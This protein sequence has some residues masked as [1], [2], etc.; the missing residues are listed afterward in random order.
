MNI[1][2]IG[3][4]GV[5]QCKG[6]DE[7]CMGAFEKAFIEGDGI[8][9]DAAV[10][11]DGTVYLVHDIA[12]I[13][14]PHIFHR[15]RYALRDHLD[16]PSRKKVGRK[17]LDQMKDTFIDTLRLKQGGKLPR[18]SDLLDLIANYPGKILDIELKGHNTADAVLDDLKK[19]FRA[20]KLTQEQVIITS[21]DHQAIRRVREVYPE[22]R[23]GF[24]V[25]R[26]ARGRTR[27][28]PWTDN[29]LSRYI[30]F[31]AKLIKSKIAKDVQ[32]DYFVMTAGSI[33]PGKVK[34]LRKFFPDSQLMVWTTKTPEKDRVL[35]KKLKHLKI[36][37]HIAG[38]ITDFPDKTVAHLKKRNLR[39]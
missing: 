24:L 35:N 21:F 38:I 31:G 39:K 10:S 8:E 3:H 27:I 36:G 28:Y 9:T 16:K 12:Q 26:Y 13:G 23:V 25:S 29:K 33:S 20:K 2:V 14:F 5:R 6:I 17:R 18:L 32:P 7:N 15:S 30:Q 4:R 19:A 37:P 34:L 11:A 22:I 1:L